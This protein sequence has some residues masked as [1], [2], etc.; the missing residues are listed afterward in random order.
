MNI[1]CSDKTG[2]LTAGEMKVH[3]A[4]NLTGHKSDSVLL[5]AYINS[6]YE[7]GFVNPIDQAI[8]RAGRDLGVD[9]SNY[10]KLDEIPFDFARKRI[11]VL[12]IQEEDKTTT[13]TLSTKHHEKLPI[14]IT[15]GAVHNVLDICSKVEVST[16][17]VYDLD[18]LPHGNYTEHIQRF[19]PKRL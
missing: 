13:T 17:V 10:Q 8:I 14:M 15:K 1:L 12:F 9:V 11:S 7:T 6:T 16:G 3:S 2:T 4:L 18:E 19:E 5:Y